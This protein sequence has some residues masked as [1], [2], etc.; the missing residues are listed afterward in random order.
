MPDP[1]GSGECDENY[2]NYCESKKPTESNSG[3]YEKEDQRYSSGEGVCEGPI[4]KKL[5][6]TLTALSSWLE[7]SF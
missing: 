2:C 1:D 3:E 5:V 4:H 6:V 7:R